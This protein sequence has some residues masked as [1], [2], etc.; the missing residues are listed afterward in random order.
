MVNAIKPVV[1]GLKRI[2]HIG[3]LGCH[4][5]MSFTL[6]A[7]KRSGAVAVM[8]LEAKW[9]GGVMTMKSPYFSIN[10]PKI[11]TSKRLC[12]GWFMST[13]VLNVGPMHTIPQFIT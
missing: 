3:F 2:V 10:L 6:W 9:L 8:A 7:L 5:V 13:A 1:A 4:R 11:Y 12:M